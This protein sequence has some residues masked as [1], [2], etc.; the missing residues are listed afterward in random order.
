MKRVAATACSWRPWS[1][2]CVA[3][4]WRWTDNSVTGC[5]PTNWCGWR[6]NNG[7]ICWSWARTATAGSATWRQGQTVSPVLHRLTIP[8]LVV[9]NAVLYPRAEFACHQLRVTNIV[10]VD[11]LRIDDRM[12]DTWHNS[13][14]QAPA[15][16][17]GDTICGRRQGPSGL[18]CYPIWESCFPRPRFTWSSAS[19]AACYGC[20]PKTLRSKSWV[21]A[22]GERYLCLHPKGM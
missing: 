3:R 10:G 19:N 8:I 1:N 14:N 2:T 5:R 22:T 20:L 18:R 11:D 4:G 7:S 6:A 9:P 15:Q 13:I 17:A 12:G 16:S 21:L